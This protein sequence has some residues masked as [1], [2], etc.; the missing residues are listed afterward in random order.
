MALPFLKP[1]LSTALV[2]IFFIVLG[3][4]VLLNGALWAAALLA[5]PRHD[6]AVV[7][8]YSIDVGIDFIGEGEQ[9]IV[10]PL[11]GSLILI[12]NTV[13]GIAV[14]RADH[15]A[16]WVLWS[17]MPVLQLIMLLSFYLLWQV[18]F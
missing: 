17:I 5:F 6:P 12:F 18:N 3:W 13:V 9:I 14:L 2:R 7:L 1:Y 10:L 15:R 4:S 8:H 16:A 11:I